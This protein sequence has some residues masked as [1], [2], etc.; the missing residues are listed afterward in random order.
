MPTVPVGQAV[1]PVLTKELDVRTPA[2]NADAEET[3]GTFSADVLSPAR[4]QAAFFYSREDRA[5]FA[6][7]DA[8]LR[9]NLTEGLSAGLDKQILAGTAGLLPVPT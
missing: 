2:E 7:M 3:T 4:I 9:E 6:G 1:F 5:K 8:A